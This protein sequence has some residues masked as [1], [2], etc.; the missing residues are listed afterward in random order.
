[1]VSTELDENV[2]RQATPPIRA[3]LMRSAFVDEAAVRAEKEFLEGL[4]A[5][6]ER[7]IKST[8]RERRLL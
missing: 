7:V 5:A 4:E 6:D 3:T 8:D 1:M 2:V